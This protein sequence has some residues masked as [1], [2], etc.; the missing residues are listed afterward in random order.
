MG[1]YA[2]RT[3][4]Q[5]GE[6]VIEHEGTRYEPPFRRE[7]IVRT[8]TRP[9]ARAVAAIL[10][11]RGKEL[12]RFTATLEDQIAE[13]EEAAVLAKA[14]ALLE[15]L[16]RALEEGATALGA[17]RSTRKQESETD[18]YEAATSMRSDSSDDH[19][20]AYIFIALMAMAV[21]VFV[22]GYLYESSLT[23][24][25]RLTNAIA[26]M[27]MSFAGD[28][29]GGVYGVR[30]EGVLTQPTTDEMKGRA[31][32]IAE[33]CGIEANEVQPLYRDYRSRSYQLGGYADGRAPDG[34]Q[35]TYRFEEG[36]RE[37]AAR[38]GRPFNV[39]ACAAANGLAAMPI[40]DRNRPEESL[41][42]RLVVMDEFQQAY[43][44]REGRFA[45]GNVVKAAGLDFG[46]GSLWVSADGQAYVADLDQMGDPARTV[47]SVT[48]RAGDDAWEPVCRSTR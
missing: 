41:T 42:S 27:E 13:Q 8:G 10:D 22:V 4:T 34:F 43:H 26:V 33:A 44:A 32:A 17:T 1:R 2:I 24:E 38:S 46:S 19:S 39:A 7:L 16:Q 30:K 45:D 11:A 15:E 48:R 28:E 40:W 29:S 21:L 23:P 6:L 20:S 35:V 47:C 37:D 12:T 25:Q 31:L 5:S 14:D 18:E 9:E 3:Y 36:T